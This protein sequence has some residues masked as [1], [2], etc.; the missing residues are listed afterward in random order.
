[1]KTKVYFAIT[2]TN[3]KQS[4]D[5]TSYKD[6]EKARWSMEV[7]ANS[8]FSDDKD[9]DYEVYISSPKQNEDIKLFSEKFEQDLKELNGL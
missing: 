5:I 1:M 2:D 9:H 3:T 8:L 7:L 4:F 6:Y